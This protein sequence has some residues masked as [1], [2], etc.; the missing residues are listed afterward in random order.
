MRL[1]GLA[2]LASALLSSCVSSSVIPLS[3][4]MIEISTTGDE[5]CGKNKTREAALKTAAL[6]TIQ[7]GFDRFIVLRAN[8]R[9]D[10]EYAGTTPVTATTVETATAKGSD[11]KVN[12]YGS[13]TTTVTG[14][15]PMFDVNFEQNL[16][17]KMFKSGDQNGANAL[18]ARTIL[19]PKIDQILAE[20]SIVTCD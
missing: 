6:E 16:T 13:S 12:A 2:I 10:V 18:D 17:I 11:N 4:D 15:D 1:L 9:K 19:G 5:V 20:G 3:A 14:G 8:A 7:R